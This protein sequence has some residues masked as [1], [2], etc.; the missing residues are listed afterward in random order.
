MKG[1]CCYK[2]VCSGRGGTQVQGCWSVFNP[3][4]L[5][6]IWGEFFCKLMM[7]CNLQFCLYLWTLI[8]LN[9]VRSKHE[10]LIALIL[11]SENNLPQHSPS[12]LISLWKSSYM[13]SS[14]L[15]NF[16]AAYCMRACIFAI[17]HASFSQSST[18]QH[19]LPWI[20]S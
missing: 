15:W 1:R 5:V 13:L 19:S 16:P 11:S 10:R 20:C 3:G 2:G 9:A 4:W 18:E 14:C 6:D 17:S 8:S 7:K 12:C